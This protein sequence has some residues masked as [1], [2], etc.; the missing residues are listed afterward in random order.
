VGERLG[1]GESWDSI[2]AGMKQVA[3]GV[4]TCQSAV[5][6]GKRYHVEMPISEAVHSVIFGN[7]SAK[8]ALKEL[9]A[10]EPKREEG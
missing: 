7:K 8:V 5:E 10:R 1:K 2:R 9:M 4:T 6:L 3:E